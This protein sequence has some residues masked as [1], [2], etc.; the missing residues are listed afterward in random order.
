MGFNP[1][2]VWIGG[3]FRGGCR[4]DGPRASLRRSERRLRT[5]DERC[6]F[7]GLLHTLRN[8]G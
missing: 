4:V 1:I 2:C 8:G 3:Y 5:P 7:N 6:N